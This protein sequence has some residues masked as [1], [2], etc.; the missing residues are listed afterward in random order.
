[1]NVTADMALNLILEKLSQQ[2]VFLCID[3]TIVPKFGK[4]F[5]DVSKLFDYAAHNGSNYLNGHCLVNIM[6]CVPVWNQNR[7]HYL[8]V[9]I[10]IFGK[11]KVHT[12]V[13]SSEKISGNRRLFFSTV[14]PEQLQI[15]CAWQEKAPLNRQGVTVCSLSLWCCMFF[16]DQSKLAITNRKY[17]SHCAVI[18]CVAVKELKCWSIWSISHS[19]QWNCC[20][21]KMRRFQNTVRKVC[22]NLD[23]PSANKSGNRYFMLFSWKKSKQA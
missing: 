10:N 15:F 7:I 20:H 17:S 19:M 18:W 9:L 8:S 13:T 16:D 4:K 22:R 5:E 1:M 6:L 3:D 14:F 11:R 21:T 23:F 12:Y 2:P